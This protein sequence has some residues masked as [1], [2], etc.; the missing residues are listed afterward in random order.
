MPSKTIYNVFS[1]CGL[2]LIAEKYISRESGWSHGEEI[3][4]T[5]LRKEIAALRN[6][7]G[8]NC[9]EWEQG[10]SSVANLS[11][12]SGHVGGGSHHSPSP[13]ESKGGENGIAEP[14]LRLG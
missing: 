6:G 4:E 10:T 11:S 13:N 3:K 8:T 1:D 14:D 5:L 2:L 7:E 12:A 9:Q